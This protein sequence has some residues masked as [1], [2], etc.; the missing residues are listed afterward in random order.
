[1]QTTKKVRIGNIV[2][3]NPKNLQELLKVRTSVSS[4]EQQSQ[5]V[6]ENYDS[7]KAYLPK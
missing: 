6:A 5:F 3:A 7:M 2:T 1:M 4:F